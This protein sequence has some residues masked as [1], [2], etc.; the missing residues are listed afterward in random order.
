MVERFLPP[1]PVQPYDVSTGAFVYGLLYHNTPLSSVDDIMVVIMA[2]CFLLFIDITLRFIIEIIEFN[3]ARKKPNTIRYVIT[4]LWFGWGSLELSN[5]KRKRFLISKKFRMSLFNKVAFTYPIFF[6]L[7]ATSWSLPDVSIYG[8]RVDYMLSV[9][10][11]LIP[12]VSEVCSIVEKLNQI[13]TTAFVWYPS[14]VNFL[15]FIKEFIRP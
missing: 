10:F 11:M 12:F 2:T 14:L 6:T 3:K 4:A 9:L 7:A 15:K 5:G 1:P 8:F 13:D